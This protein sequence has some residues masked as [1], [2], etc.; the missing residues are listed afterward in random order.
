MITDLQ[1]SLKS[2]CHFF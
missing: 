1:K 2:A